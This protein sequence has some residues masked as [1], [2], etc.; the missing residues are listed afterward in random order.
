MHGTVEYCDA[1]GF[2]RQYCSRRSEALV[3]FDL[4]IAP[5]GWGGPHIWTRQ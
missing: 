5:A 2:Y 3:L 4:G 1:V